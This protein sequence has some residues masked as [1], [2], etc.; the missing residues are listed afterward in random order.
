VMHAQAPQ[1]AEQIAAGLRK[2]LPDLEIPIGPIGIV[3]GTHAGPKALGLV[4][5]KK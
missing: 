3:L 1:E 4:W 2:T 5:I